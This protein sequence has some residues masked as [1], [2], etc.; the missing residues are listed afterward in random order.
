MPTL[1]RLFVPVEVQLRTHP[2]FQP[3]FPRAPRP[4]ALQVLCVFMKFRAQLQRWPPLVLLQSCEQV[5]KFRHSLMSG[6]HMEGSHRALR[7]ESLPLHPLFLWLPPPTLTSRLARHG[8]EA[9]AAGAVGGILRADAARLISTD[10]GVGG[11][12]GQLGVC[13]DRKWVPS[14]D[15]LGPGFWLLAAPQK[16]P[17]LAHQCCSLPHRTRPHSHRTCCSAGRKRGSAGSGT[18]TPSCP[19]SGQPGPW[20]TL[21]RGGASGSGY[22]P[23]LLL[24]Q[25]PQFAHHRYRW[26]PKACRG[27]C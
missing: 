11:A 2:L 18:E 8:V 17:A 21:G 7:P 1:C 5:P 4:S 10:A 9:R 20:G 19:C 3:S 6:S 15:P 13:G 24:P 14:P 23:L 22:S 26:V 12:A 16:G 25:G 27:S